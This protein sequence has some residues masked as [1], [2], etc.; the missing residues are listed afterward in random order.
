M[1]ASTEEPLELRDTPCTVCPWRRDA[2]MTRFGRHDIAMLARAHGEPGAEAPRTAPMISCHCDQ[3]GTPH[4][5]RLCAGWLAAEGRQHFG[6]R[7]HQLAG[8]LP[9]TACSPGPGWPELVADFAEL[10]TRW[11]RAHAQLR[12][13]DEEMPHV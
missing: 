4:A 7:I 11:R 9:E 13:R 12:P 8:T 10:V 3:P 1:P 5:M 6:V 2:D